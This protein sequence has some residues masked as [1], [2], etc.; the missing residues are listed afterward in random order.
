MKTKIVD[1]PVYMYVH[2]SIHNYGNAVGKLM[3]NLIRQYSIT[4]AIIHSRASG[5]TEVDKQVPYHL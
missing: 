1:V 4:A 3:L 5:E 2:I